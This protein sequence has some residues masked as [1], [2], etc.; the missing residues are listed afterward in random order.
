MVAEVDLRTQ[1]WC[2]PD[3]N[4]VKKAGAVQHVLKSP[5]MCRPKPLGGGEGGMVEIV[6]D[7]SDVTMSTK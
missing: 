5:T 1:Q 4:M 6:A 7:I 3:I 2:D